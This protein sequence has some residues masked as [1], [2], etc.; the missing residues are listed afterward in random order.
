M[1]SKQAFSLTLG[2]YNLISMSSKVFLMKLSRLLY[3]SSNYVKFFL[4]F[5]IK[6]D[7]NIPTKYIPGKY[8]KKLGADFLYERLFRLLLDIENLNTK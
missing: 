2:Q 3:S 6:Y 4:L 5:L 1:E 7:A 8:G